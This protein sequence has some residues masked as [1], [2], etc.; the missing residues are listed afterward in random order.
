MKKFGINGCSLLRRP[1]Y[2]LSLFLL[3]LLF[4]CTS[5]EKSKIGTMRNIQ[6]GDVQETILTHSDVMDIQEWI[7]LDSLQEC[8][9]GDVA[10]IEEFNNE[11]Y[12]LDK[13]VQKCVLVFDGHG[14][15]LRRIGNIGQGPGEY[16]QICDFT[17]N[18][19]TG[20][21]AI[22]SGQ[23]RVYVY[24]LAGEFQTEKQVSESV[25]WSIVSNDCGYFMS[26]DHRTY[27]EGENAY[28]L[29]AFDENFNLKGKWGQVL[30]RQMPT[31]PLLSSALQAAGNEIYYCDIFTNSVYRYICGAD[32]VTGIYNISFPSPIPE[33]ILSDVMAFM[34]KQREYDFICEAVM[35]ETNTLLCY[36]HQGSYNLAMVDFGGEIL[37]N[38][39]YL[40]RFPKVFHGNDKVLLSP[41]SANE[42]L[43]YWKE[44]PVTHYNGVLS[45][46]SNFMILKWSV[47]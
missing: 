42:Y 17:V 5:H 33:M 16:T 35:N 29:Y 27:T 22:L 38:G 46:E 26:S 25:L 20:C 8:I 21:V 47:K 2:F 15:Y 31:L 1:A 45:D 23:S 19:S 4:S 37:K 32:S 39:K 18:K 12:L 28:L 11:Y 6:L 13:V 43:S 34:E 36:S 7:L 10:K 14:K 3:V 9:I 30:S 24:N 41:V 44:Q 40:G